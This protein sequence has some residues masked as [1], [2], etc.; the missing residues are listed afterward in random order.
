MVVSGQEWGMEYLSG[1]GHP[2][3]K[4]CLFLD[5]PFDKADDCSRVCSMVEVQT[6]TGWVVLSP[7]GYSL[8]STLRQNKFKMWTGLSL[9]LLFASYF[10]SGIPKGDRLC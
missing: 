1:E 7:Y 2:H 6:D 3:T 9:T 10:L 4:V 5:Y 8:L